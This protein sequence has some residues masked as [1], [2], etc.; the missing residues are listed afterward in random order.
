MNIFAVNDYTWLATWQGKIYKQ[1]YFGLNFLSNIIDTITLGTIERNKTKNSK[2]Y[3]WWCALTLVGK[4][5]IKF[6]G[7]DEK[8][9]ITY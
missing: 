2:I 5:T 8:F 4:Y 3:S 1:K 7:P 9:N 6:P